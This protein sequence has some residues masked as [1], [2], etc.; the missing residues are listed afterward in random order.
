ML[1]KLAYKKKQRRG[2]NSKKKDDGDGF[3]IVKKG[4]RL[5]TNKQKVG[6]HFYEGIRKKKPQRPKRDSK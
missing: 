2:K 4:P 5:T 6:N 3:D 1:T